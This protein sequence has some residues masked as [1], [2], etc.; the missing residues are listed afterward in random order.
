MEA[1]GAVGLLY[2]GL[3]VFII[4]SLWRVNTKAGQPGWAVLIPIYN[5]YV[6]LK[7]A[8]KPGWW[9]LLFLI[10]VVNIVIAILMYAGIAEKFGK[11]AGFA[12][13]LIFISII[14]FPILAFGNAEYTA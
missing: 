7:V 13:G 12:I 4:A 3:M 14:F 1:L 8:G 5:V 10:P 6:L 9:L 2:F 11:G